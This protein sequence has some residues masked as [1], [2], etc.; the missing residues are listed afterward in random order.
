MN[1]IDTLEEYKENKLLLAKERS[2]LEEKIKNTSAKSTDNA[3]EI[4]KDMQNRIRKTYIILSRV[5]IFL[6]SKKVTLKKHC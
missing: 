1:E 2:D 6:T 3:E 5:M 4:K